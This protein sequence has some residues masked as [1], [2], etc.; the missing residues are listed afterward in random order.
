MKILVTANHVPFLHGGADH[1]IHGLVAALREHGHD[2]ELLRLPFRFQP[3]ADVERLMSYCETL[4]MT[5][6]NGQAVD[7]LISLQF[8]GYGIHH[9]AH[10]VWVMHQHRAVY[11][12]FDDHQ[13]TPALRQLRQAVIDYD[14][15]HLGRVSQ[16]FANSARVAE[17]L[18]S[19]NGL[20]A[21]PLYHPPHGA[22]RLY[23]AEDWGYVFYP[24]RLEGLK[25]QDL[26]IEAARHLRSPA[27]ILI[28][29]DGG[30]RARYEA[31]I[32]RHDLKDRVTLTG[33][34]S[35]AQKLACYAHALAV[36]FGPFDEDYGYIT[37]EAMLAA[38]PVITCT[39]SGGPLEFVR[40]DETG[41]VVEPSPEA[42]A[43]AIDAAWANRRL[44]AEM[45]QAGR[46]AYQAHG[47]GW[48]SVV[49][50]LL[51]QEKA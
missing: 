51:G 22:E 41:W 27:K 20:A 46:E 37:L 3:E 40:H 7:R 36:F 26:L 2:T 42:V 13:A 19:H 49:A 5:R 29:G 11:E 44:A 25:R 28:A 38:K 15:R 10:T 6:P 8:P 48:D 33:Q 14:N 1:H 9:P 23:H 21:T 47:I 39:D 35:E 32:E 16:L 31:I 43:E 4:D 50:R 18:A 24:S 45:G 17:R 34:I 12:L 30:Q